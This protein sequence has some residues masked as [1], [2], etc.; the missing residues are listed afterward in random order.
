L[1]GAVA[2]V[3]L[4]LI[5][6]NFGLSVLP[7]VDT[8]F[9]ASAMKA[10]PDSKAFMVAFDQSP[11][12]TDSNPRSRV[13]LLENGVPLILKQ[14]LPTLVLTKGSGAWSH[15]RGR[16]FFSTPDNSDP[17]RNSRTYAARYPILYGR[18]YGYGAFV[19]LALSAWLLRRARPPA[20]MITE[21][22]DPATASPDRTFRLHVAAAALIFIGTL[23]CATG[24]LA[25]YANTLIPRV[26]P[27]TGYLYNIDLSVHRAA[28][29]FVDGQPRAAWED[30]VILRRILY[31]VL[32]WPVQKTLGY[33]TGGVGF[34]LVV[35]L[36]GFLAGVVLVR[37]RVGVRGATLAAW[38]LA[39]YPG[40]A[41]WA[42]QPF[43]YALI[44]PLSIAGF[45]ILLEL[46]TA[47]WRKNALLS[48]GLGVIYLAYD[49][50]IYFF[51]ASIVLFL[52]H[53]RFR[54]ALLSG[55][56]QALPPALWLLALRYLVKLPL[57]NSNTV[58]YKNLIAGFFDFSAPGEMLARVLALPEVGTDIF[59]GANFLFLPA[60]VI[61]ALA[62]D[63]GWRD[64]IRDRAVPA[65]L[66]TGFGLLVFCNLPPPQTGPWNLSGAW[67]ARLYQPVFP[68]LVLLLARWWQDR[69]PA[70]AFAR[71]SRLGLVLLAVGGNALICF[72]SL[73]TPPGTVAET[74]W[75]RF[76]DHTDLHW[77]FRYNLD[78]YGRRPLGFPHR[79]EHP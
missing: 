26:D 14:R 58:A 52:W 32:A 35:N 50:P 31:S 34:N 18:L 79:M 40:A 5:F 69:Q 25:P 67:I 4:L 21:A 13:V 51:P 41:Y 63:L 30:S 15:V 33:E 10:I 65:L 43:S 73:A 3:A 42:G 7:E 70:A 75:Y 46:P 47:G 6:H 60:L 37:R 56:L 23:Y 76:Y 48:L 28:F 61:A 74:A 64:V 77:I 20:A 78:R 29:A 54:P 49:F 44:F 53:R 17:R 55:A 22:P 16:I 68:A 19:L 45:W 62:L 36:A 11:F 38:L 39:F 8:T 2:A 71:A 12:D 24:T 27:A 72:G 57:E 1:W 9:D 59:F 66:V